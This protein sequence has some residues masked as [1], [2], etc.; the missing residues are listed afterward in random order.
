MRFPVKIFPFHFCDKLNVV[1]IPFASVFVFLQ[2]HSEC[3][4][5]QM[6]T[7]RRAMILL[8]CILEAYQEEG[9]G[10]DWRFCLL[11]ASILSDVAMNNVTRGTYTAVSTKVV[12]QK[13]KS[14][15]TGKCQLVLIDPD[16]HCLP[17]RKEQA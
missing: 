17:A 10:D 4:K 12:P 14:V 9:G 5:R 13:R 11:A 6:L 3:P 1:A 15:R 7:E 2:V 8:R 16:S